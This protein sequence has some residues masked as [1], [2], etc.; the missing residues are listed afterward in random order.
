MGLAYTEFLLEF[1]RKNGYSPIVKGEIVPG[2]NGL[3]GDPET[4]FRNM[5]HWMCIA[6]ELA[7]YQRETNTKE[8]VCD[9]V[10]TLIRDFPG[11]HHN[12]F[13]TSSQGQVEWADRHGLDTGSVVQDVS[14]LFTG[15]CSRVGHKLD[16]A[17]PI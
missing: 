15:C 12:L 5:S 10:N 11:C 17:L 8:Y 13:C 9:A 16:G 4:I 3:Y 7:K 2:N 14:G 6:C 1:W